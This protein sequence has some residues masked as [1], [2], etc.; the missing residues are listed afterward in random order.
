MILEY[1]VTDGFTYFATYNNLYKL[2]APNTVSLAH[3]CTTTEEVQELK[4]YKRYFFYAQTTTIGRLNLDT[5]I[6]DDIWRTGMTGTKH[7]M[8]VS[9]DNFMYI[10]AGQYL[11]RWDGSAYAPI[12]LD[13]QDGWDIECLTNFGITFLA[14]GANYIGSQGSTQSKI[15]LWDR[16][17]PTWND[18]IEIPE[19]K[20]HTMISCKGGLWVWASSSQMSIYFIPLGSRSAIKVFTFENNN[21]VLY[22]SRVYRNAVTFKNGRV[23]FGY[24]CNIFSSDQSLPG[25]YSFNQD[26]TKFQITR[27]TFY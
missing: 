16:I 20:I 25:V 13:L 21:P 11:D 27:R 9:A 7:P 10:G 17:A 14:I 26:P 8:E 2:T 5:H 4:E 22:P 19:Q 12:A 24:S 15:F 23:Y 1:S 6:Y 3:T 18:E